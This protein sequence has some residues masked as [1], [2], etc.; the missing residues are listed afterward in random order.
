MTEKET[1]AST[2]PSNNHQ[3]STPTPPP[4]PSYPSTTK[5]WLIMISLYLAIFLVALDKTILATAIPRITD[6]FSSLADIGWYGSSYM[7]TLCSFQLLWGRIYT[8]YS[9]KS[10]FLFSI[11]VF[12]IG[13]AICGAA[14]TSAVFI[15]GRAIAGAGSSGISSGSIVIVMHTV[16]LAKRPIFQGLIGA[17]FGVASVVGPLLGGAFTE[18]L[19]WRWCF[20]INLPCGAVSV[21]LLVLILRLPKKK[22]EEGR[23]PLR[24]QLRKLDP[25]GTALFLPSV[26]CLLLALQWGGTTYSWSNPRIIAL[27]TLFP[28]LFAAFVGTQ[29]WKKDTAQLPMQILTQRTIASSFLFTFTSQASMLVITYFI[30]LYFQALK[31][32]APLDSGLAILPLILLLMIGTILAGGLVQRF[33]YPAPFMLVSSILS[34]VG[35]GLISTW[36]IETGRGVWIG[37]QVLFGF[38]LGLGMQQ[39]TMSAQIVL[40]RKDVPTGISLMFFGQNLGGAVF[41]SVAQN[42]FVSKLAGKLSQ[43]PGQ[44]FDRKTVVEMGATKVREMVPKEL[45]GMVL[46]GYRVSLKGA[47]YVGL[48]LAC[49]SLVGAVFV[50]WKSVKDG[51]KGVGGE[52]EESGNGKSVD[53]EVE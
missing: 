40:Q 45:L 18:R 47:F 15:I 50:E 33:G 30:P 48:G 42:V 52:K 31:S 35:A 19:S 43:L 21:T 25:L 8:F 36:R 1:F 32:F 2:S 6:A 23:I 49:V 34:A 27:M 46:E 9:P 51:E 12:E 10:V 38:G 16:P 3:P 17:V 41:V 13:S 22:E 26:V 20:W 5:T 29:V 39:P 53:G 37:Y 24:Q 11:L 14:P 4:S 28:V 7:L 44:I